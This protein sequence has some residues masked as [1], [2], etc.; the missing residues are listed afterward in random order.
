MTARKSSKKIKKITVSDLQSY[1]SGAIDLNVDD[2]H[3]NK[4]QW[5]KIVDMIMNLKPDEV[6]TRE[7]HVQQN[8][9]RTTH[10][11]MTGGYSEP[12]MGGE[13]NHPNTRAPKTD[14]RKIKVEN[15]GTYEKDPNTGVVRSGIKI[16]TPSIDT[17]IKDYD[18]P[19][20]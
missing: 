19:F 2:W 10:S 8:P 6:V 5:E 7:V 16:K 9:Q 18:T 14:F 20:A 3:P 1:I 12:V 13:S 17:S 11:A 15:N 4:E